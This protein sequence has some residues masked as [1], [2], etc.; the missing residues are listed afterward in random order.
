[1]LAFVHII[2]TATEYSGRLLAWL[3]L[4]MALLT[5]VIVVLRYMVLASSAYVPTWKL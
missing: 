2:D 4:A 3:T 1:M 5:G